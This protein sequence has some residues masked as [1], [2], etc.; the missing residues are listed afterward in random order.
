M[1]D[2]VTFADYL[3]LANDP[4]P[5]DKLWMKIKPRKNKPIGN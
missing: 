2:E 5:T 3:F 1:I 4:N